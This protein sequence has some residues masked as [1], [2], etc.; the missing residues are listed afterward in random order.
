MLDKL[1]DQLKRFPRLID[2]IKE[3]AVFGA[4]KAVTTPKGDEVDVLSNVNPT[5]PVCES[6]LLAYEK[7]LN[8]QLGICENIHRPLYP[9]MTFF[10]D[11]LEKYKRLTPSV[12]GKRATQ[13]L[14]S[15]AGGALNSPQQKG[16]VIDLGTEDP[17]PTFTPKKVDT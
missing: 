9:R 16:N 4:F 10:T 1:T 6:L 14:E 13:L 3:L 12:Q 15:L 8:N 11:M 7:R 5:Y 2:N 17:D